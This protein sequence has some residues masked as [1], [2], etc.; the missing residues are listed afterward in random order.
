MEASVAV[1]PNA[2]RRARRSC[3]NIGKLCEDMKASSRLC[4]RIAASLELWHNY[5]GTLQGK[6]THTPR[7]DSALAWGFWTPVETFENPGQP[8]T[9]PP[10]LIA[11]G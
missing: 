11:M 9:G 2:L 6:G 1:G 3:S 10:A 8:S 5:N 4:K 7:F